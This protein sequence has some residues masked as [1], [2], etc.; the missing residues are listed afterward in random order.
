MYKIT[1]GMVI[2]Q[3]NY[4][5]YMVSLV[6]MKKHYLILM[7]NIIMDVITQKTSMMT[8]IELGILMQDVFTK[9]PLL[10][11]LMTFALHLMTKI[12]IIQCAKQL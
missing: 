4:L 3:Y 7:K 11:L 5:D 6:I 8:L 2:Q 12:L 10:D 9:I 1:I